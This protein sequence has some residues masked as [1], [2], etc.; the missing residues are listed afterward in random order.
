MT[1]WQSGITATVVASGSVSTVQAS[2]LAPQQCKRYG[3]CKQL[4]LEQHQLQHELQVL[5]LVVGM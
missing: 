3:T 4:G 2:N 5:A 1:R